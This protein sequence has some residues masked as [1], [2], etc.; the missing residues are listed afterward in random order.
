M[1]CPI[2]LFRDQS[3]AVAIETAIIIP[4][5]ILLSLGGFETSRMVSRQHELQSGVGEAEAVALAANAGATTDTV[6]L[7]AMLQESLGLSAEQVV[8]EKR[9]RCDSNPTL[10]TQPD[11][12]E[13]AV[14]SSYL[15]LKLEDTY[16][17]AWRNLGLGTN[18][19]F[20]VERTVQLS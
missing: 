20:D 8:V 16:T 11:C 3:G 1:T 10:I 7:K 9:Y 5:L 15:H 4:V 2:R 13:D 14:V 6:K 17:P 12:D 19:H 18:I